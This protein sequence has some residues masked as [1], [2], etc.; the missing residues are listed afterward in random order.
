LYRKT[1]V[2]IENLTGSLPRVRSEIRTICGVDN[3]LWLGTPR[4]VMILRDCLSGRFG[5][6]GTAIPRIRKNPSVGAIS[7]QTIGQARR[8]P[9]IPAEST[10][11]AVSPDTTMLAYVHSEG[12][13]KEIYLHNT[14]SGVS[15]PLLN[16]PPFAVAL[17]PEFSPDGQ[18]LVFYA[19]VEGDEEIFLCDIKS[20]SLLRLTKSKGNDWDPQFSPSGNEIVFTSNRFGDNDILRYDLAAKNTTR[21]TDDKA[22]EWHPVFTPDGQAIVYI[23]ST[24]VNPGNLWIMDASSGANKRILVSNPGK[25]WMQAMSPEGRYLAFCTHRD[26]AHRL[27]IFEMDNHSQTPLPAGAWNDFAPAWSPDGS[28]LYFHSDR[29][30]I[31]EIWKITLR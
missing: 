14:S 20:Q 24:Q 22:S 29:G 31:N 13:R 23:K 25:D 10:Q 21:L 17:G 30:G 2:T 11:P 8:V 15:R 1:G 4:G 16:H 7:S 26:S 28:E 9:G 3:D 18:R 19:E 27:M 12:N 6:N 5:K